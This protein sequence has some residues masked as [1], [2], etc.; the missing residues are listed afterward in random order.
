MAARSR[1]ASLVALACVAS[2]PFVAASPAH[3]AGVVHPIRFPVD[4]PVHYS[5]DFGA[6]RA[7][8]RTHQ[9]ND[10]MG[11]KLTREVAA[12]D[13]V[14]TYVHNDGDGGIS[15][16][17]LILSAVDGW[18]YYYIHINNDTPGTDDGVNPAAWRYAPGIGVGSRVIAGEFIAYMGDSGDAET[19]A[20]HL[21]FEIHPPRADNGGA[22]IDPYPSL[23]A[24]NHD[25]APTVV[26]EAASPKAGAYVLTNDGRVHAFGGATPYGFDLVPAGLARAIAVMPD[27]AGYVMLDGWGGLHLFGS[28]N[29]AFAGISVGYWPGW[30]IARAVAITPTGKGVAVLDGF[31]GVHRFGDAPALATT[32][33]LGND[34]GRGI[35][36]TPSGK[37]GYVL[38]GWGGVTSTGDAIAGTAP[39]WPGWDIARGIAVSASGRGYAVLDGWGG[40]HPVGDAP[41]GPAGAYAPGSDWRGIAISGS[42]YALARRD[43]LSGTW[44]A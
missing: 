4:G 20:P 17:M 3:A 15:G 27:G 6:P 29:A 7:G 40:V 1:I 39:T 32:Y 42:R 16:N 33:R 2:V 23:Q 21:H 13:G 19:T 25:P 43:G 24:A 26:A 31:G 12:A 34:L 11:A 36:F 37:G 9:G 18:S 8:G 10:I 38:D 35:A 22:A 30:D 14:I 41:A 28:A 44:S 5:S